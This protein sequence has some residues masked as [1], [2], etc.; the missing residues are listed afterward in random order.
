MKQMTGEMTKRKLAHLTMSS[1][2]LYAHGNAQSLLCVSNKNVR[3]YCAFFYFCLRWVEVGGLRSDFTLP[4]FSLLCNFFIHYLQYILLRRKLHKQRSLFFDH[5][6]VIY[7]IRI[8]SM[9]R[10]Y[11]S[12]GVIF[13][14]N[15]IFWYFIVFS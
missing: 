2:R 14:M 1:L 12:F 6:V 13:L 7:W 9:S 10:N 4:C 11:L 5:S 15:Y 3:S 8:Y